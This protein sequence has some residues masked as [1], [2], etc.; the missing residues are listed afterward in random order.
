MKWQTF[1]NGKGMWVQWHKKVKTVMPLC[2]RFLTILFRSIRWLFKNLVWSLIKRSG[3]SLHWLQL[4]ELF[5]HLAG[6][7]CL[8]NAGRLRLESNLNA[9]RCSSLPWS[10]PG[11][12][13]WWAETQRFHL[14]WITVINSTWGWLWRWFRNFIWFKMQKSRKDTSEQHRGY[15]LVLKDSFRNV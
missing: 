3:I 9:K 5:L 7:P 11:E 15:H 6:A 12:I 8:L 4:R 2:H 1:S 14:I 13:H 10:S